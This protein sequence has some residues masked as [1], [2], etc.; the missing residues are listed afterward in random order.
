[1]M[2]FLVCFVCGICCGIVTCALLFL[3]VYSLI[4]EDKQNE[5]IK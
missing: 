2:N 4:Q 1:M 3:T 5:Q